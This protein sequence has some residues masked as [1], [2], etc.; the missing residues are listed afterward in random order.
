[1]RR[2]RLSPEDE[3][4]WALVKR[5]T[6][7]LRPE[8]EPATAPAAAAAP[9]PA[10]GALPMAAPKAR[11]SRPLLAPVDRRTR[12]RL[13]RGRLPIDGRLDLHGLNQAAAHDRLA[14]FLAEAQRRG[15][16][17][18]L[19]ITGKGQPADGWQPAGP[20]RGVLRRVVPFWLALPAFRRLVLGFEEAQD[21]H[22]GTGAIYV[23]VRKAQE[24]R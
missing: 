1:M 2:S 7:P 14:G 21:L 13:G 16:R 15:H 5:S 22:G 8:P 3:A 9:E 24:R 20:E 6:R 17:I 4:L 11:P 12:Q 23:L 18:V 19:V 10:V